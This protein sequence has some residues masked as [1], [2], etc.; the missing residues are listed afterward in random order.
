MPISNLAKV[1]QLPNQCSVAKSNKKNKQPCNSN[2]IVNSH[3]AAAQ[4]KVGERYK[5]KSY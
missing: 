5:A 2:E 1:C 4:V 3:E